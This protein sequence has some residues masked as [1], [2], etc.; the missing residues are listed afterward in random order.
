MSPAAPG[1]T[2]ADGSWLL[3]H[4]GLADD[5]GAVDLIVADGRI[6][7]IERGAGAVRWVCLPPLA[8]L[9]VH[10][11]RAFTPAPARPRGLDDAARNV[12]E[13]MARFGVDD[14]R[15]HAALLF[16][17]ARSHATTR[18]RTHADV[19]AGS[20]LAAVAGTLQAAA[21][22]A[23]DMEIETVAFA[24]AGSDPVTVEGRRR[25]REAVALGAGFLGAAPA[26]CDDPK[27]TIDAVLD[28]A[29]ELD[30]PVDLHLDEHLQASAC[31]SG[32]LAQA[33]SRRGLEGQVTLGHGCAIAI[34]DDDERR[35]TLDQ[36]AAARITV[37]ALPR[38]NLYLQ[39]ATGTVPRHRGIVNVREMIRHGI[40]V[41]FA[42]DNVRDAF[43]PFGDADLI[44]VAMD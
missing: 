4:V 21:E 18:V 22:F 26:F 36:L 2:R 25:L 43:Y 24:A 35:R 3:R 41:R 37:I 10:A 38:T 14:H 23:P 6:E 40:P 39:D 5:G 7:S 31:L 8:D 9:H 19:D 12:A 32:H 42:S 34:L 20:G 29:G 15:R 44:G 27:A 1:E 13:T 30:V 28:L 33:V 11:N 17:A 16:A